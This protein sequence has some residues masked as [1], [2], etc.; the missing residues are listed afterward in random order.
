MRYKRAAELLELCET[1]GLALPLPIDAI[2]DLEDAGHV[3]DLATGE[4]LE[5]G[6]SWTV[7]PATGEPLRIHDACRLAVMRKCGRMARMH[8][9]IDELNYTGFITPA[10]LWL[11][12][13]T[14]FVLDFDT[15]LVQDTWRSETTA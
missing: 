12:E 6:A 5:D 4:I 8:S 14:G 3:V 7:E 2:L 13:S 10:E 11:L 1:A 9:E 15:G